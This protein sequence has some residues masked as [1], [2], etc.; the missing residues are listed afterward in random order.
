VHERGRGSG[1]WLCEGGREKSCQLCWRLRDRRAA[2]GVACFRVSSV[3][4][5]VRLLWAVFLSFFPISPFY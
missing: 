3:L 1:E 4:D 2:V 5:W